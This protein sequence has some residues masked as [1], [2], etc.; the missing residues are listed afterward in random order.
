MSYTTGPDN[1]IVNQ[2]RG[3]NSVVWITEDVIPGYPSDQKTMVF[4]TDQSLKSASDRAW[5]VEKAIEQYAFNRGYE[6]QKP[7]GKFKVIAIYS[8]DCHSRMLANKLKEQIKETPTFLAAAESAKAEAN[9]LNKEYGRYINEL[10]HLVYLLEQAL[11]A[12]LKAVAAELVEKQ[13]QLIDEFGSEGIKDY[14]LFGDKH[15]FTEIKPTHY[16]KTSDNIPDDFDKI[17]DLL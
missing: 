17:L 2:E 4:E 5:N 8:E 15:P 1:I 14:H 6:T 3:S 10:K 12:K 9:Q 13:K 7:Y 16:Y 11:D